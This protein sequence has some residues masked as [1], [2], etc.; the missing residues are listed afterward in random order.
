MHKEGRKHTE[1][2]WAQPGKQTEQDWAPPNHKV[3]ALI[4]IITDCPGPERTR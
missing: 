2:S 4:T 1:C 3:Q